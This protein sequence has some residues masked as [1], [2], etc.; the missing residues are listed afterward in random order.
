MFLSMVR[1]AYAIL[2]SVKKTC[3]ITFNKIRRV[4]FIINT[5]I[6]LGERVSIGKNCSF[7]GNIKI[8]D[9]VTFVSNNHVIGNVKIGSNVIFAANS[10][11]NSKNHDIGEQSDA[12]PYGTKYDNRE[13]IIENNIWVGNN[14]IILPGVHVREGAVIGAGSVV[15]KNVDICSIVAGN[16]AKEIKKRSIIRYQFLKGHNLFLNDIRGF[17]Y[18]SFIKHKKL[19]R[20][21]EK[22]IKQKGYIYNYELD[23]KKPRRA[24][25]VLYDFYVAN[26]EECVFEVN[27]QGVLVKRL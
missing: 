5:N 23:K 19:K 21:L 12:L 24:N 14:V 17:S 11:I 1:R 15:T 13:V 9:N 7:S 10:I 6:S 20:E 8:G 18:Y 22:C 26:K 25:K 3:L 27:E 4:R 16:P 2:K